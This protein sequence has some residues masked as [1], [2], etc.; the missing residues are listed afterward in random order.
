[1]VSILEES[2][3]YLSSGFYVGRVYVSASVF[4]GRFPEER[5][6]EIRVSQGSVEATVAYAKVFYGRPPHYRAWVEIFGI[7]PFVVLEEPL[8]FFDSPVEDVLLSVFSENLRGGEWFFVEYV[9]DSVTLKQLLSGFPPSTTRLGFKLYRLGFTWFKD[10]YF[11]EGFMEGNPKLQAEKPLNEKQW[12]RSLENILSEIEDVL[13]K[14]G[15]RS[16]GSLRN[17]ELAALANAKTLAKEIT[18]KLSQH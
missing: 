16:V 12:R 2:V 15:G 11:P 1:M 8:E 17:Y 10:W 18:Q 9:S 6:L 14:Y 4:K 5:N 3:G 7:K 13:K